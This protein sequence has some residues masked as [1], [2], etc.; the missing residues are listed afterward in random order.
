MNIKTLDVAGF[1]ASIR[2]MRLPKRSGEKSDSMLHNYMD[3]YDEILD[4]NNNP[5]LSRRVIWIT[6]NG[7]DVFV[8]GE[9]D[10]SLAQSLIKA[11][12][13]HAKFVRGI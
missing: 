7:T 2:A 8:V 11:G 5:S 4:L 9:N 10:L 6:D 1:I 13:E 3:D 12:T